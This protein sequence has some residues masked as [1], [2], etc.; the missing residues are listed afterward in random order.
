MSYCINPLC[1]HRQNHN[2]DHVEECLSCGTSLLINDRIRLV[3][4]LRALTND[5]YNYIEVFEVDDAGTQWNP[6]RK[7]RVMKVLKWNSPKLV[8]LI[9]RESLCLQKIRHSGIPRSTIDDFFT[10]VPSNNSLTLHC[11]VMDKIEGQ[12]LE[13]WLESNSPI[14]QSLSLEW[15]QHLVDILDTVHRSNF[16]HR[17]IKPSNIILKPSGQLALID[18]GAARQ[19]TDTYLAKVSGSGGTSTGRGGR[20][21]I[22]AISTPLYSPLEQVNGKAVPQSDFY[23][24]GRTFVYLTTATQLID[25]PTDKKTGNLVWRDKAPQIDKPLA[26]FIDELMASLP[27][28][29]PQTTEVILQRLEKLP[30]QIKNYRLANSKVFKYSKYTLMVLGFVGGVFLSIPLAANYLVTQGQKL[31]A[32]NNSQEAQEF[33]SLAIKISPQLKV[34]VAEF[35]FGKASRNLDNPKIARKYFNQVIKYNP[36]DASAYSNLALVCQD[37]RDSKC[38]IESYEKAFK[39]KPNSWESHYGL[40]KFYEDQEKYDL[41]QKEYKIAIEQS[42]KAVLAVA[43]LSRLK[44]KNNEHDAAVNL[45]LKGLKETTDPE[46]QAALYKDL[47]WARLR[48]NKLGQAKKYLEEAIKLDGRTDAF[49]LLSQVEEASGNIDTARIYIEGCM[50][51]KSSLPEVFNWRQELLNR[52][53][54]K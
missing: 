12:N 42:D 26:D 18:F 38:V 43:S 48:Q 19:V 8:E 24:L 10:F 32:A 11:L 28:Q 36:K 2:S 54:K 49:C 45:A 31:E 27:G 3:K 35:Y 21:E 7:Q 16:F 4:P 5:P 14:S 53:L 29:R 44:N 34:E 25:L 50:L 40:G 39:L 9:E 52:I 30:K 22:T 47:G 23:A 37:L 17:D 46:I 41:A 1:N 20:Y 6:V 33:F 13:R 15:L 51:A